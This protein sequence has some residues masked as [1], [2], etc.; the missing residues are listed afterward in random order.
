MI[1]DRIS[2]RLK[3]ALI[4]FDGVRVRAVRWLGVG[5]GNLDGHRLSVS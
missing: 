5:R 3:S 4:D 1:L 2:P